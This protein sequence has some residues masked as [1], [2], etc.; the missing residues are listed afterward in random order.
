VILIEAGPRIL[1]SFTEDLS[2]YAHASL[3]RQGVEIQLGQAVREC[4]AD[5][6]IYGDRPLATPSK[7]QERIRNSVANSAAERKLSVLRTLTGR[8]KFIPGAANGLN[9]IEFKPLIDFGP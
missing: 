1:P 3:E 9:D 5:G 4:S 2:A 6:V 7:T 8:K